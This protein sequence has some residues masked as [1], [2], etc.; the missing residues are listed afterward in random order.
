MEKNQ[1]KTLFSLVIFSPRNFRT[2]LGLSLKRRQISSFAHAKM[3][4]THPKPHAPRRMFGPS[5]SLVSHGKNQRLG[6]AHK[7]K[8][9]M[10][11]GIIR[12]GRIRARV[13]Y[14]LNY[15]EFQLNPNLFSPLSD[16]KKGR[17]ED[18]G[19][20]KQS[21]AIPFVTQNRHLHKGRRVGRVG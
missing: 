20:G 15:F 8:L 2:I 17:P 10:I 21:E 3:V 11:V 1:M 7:H 18:F 6:G 12:L 14:N 19:H 16:L 5:F 9:F 4:E 13:C